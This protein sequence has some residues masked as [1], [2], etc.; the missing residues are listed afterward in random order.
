MELPLPPG[1]HLQQPHVEG[2]RSA[3]S[4]RGIAREEEPAKIRAI[5]RAQSVKRDDR[6]SPGFVRKAMP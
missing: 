4:T 5:C 2:E 6:S 3:A 1:L